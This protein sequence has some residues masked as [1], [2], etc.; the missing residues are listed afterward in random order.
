MYALSFKKLYS[1]Y[2]LNTL[3]CDR[4]NAPIVITVVAVQSGLLELRKQTYVRVF[5]SIPFV[6]L[7]PLTC[8]GSELSSETAI[9]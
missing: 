3:N 2:Y 8:S 4:L 1:F 6:L 7:D 5:S 9:P